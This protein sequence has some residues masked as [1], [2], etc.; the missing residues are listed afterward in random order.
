MQR[1]TKPN[2]RDIVQTGLIIQFLII[3][4]KRGLFLHYAFQIESHANARYALS[5]VGPARIECRFKSI[6]GK[7]DS[8]FALMMLHRATT[9]FRALQESVN[10]VGAEFNKK[11]GIRFK[12]LMRE[13][14][15][16]C[17]MAL[18][19]GGAGSEVL[20]GHPF[21]GSPRWAERAAGRDRAA[22]E[23]E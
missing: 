23:K 3:P 11:E 1:L 6:Q 16:A 4:L 8:D 7:T 22:A 2:T 19:R 21:D 15:P 18:K 13:A 20:T 12:R 10:P 5:M 9:L 17:R 14:F